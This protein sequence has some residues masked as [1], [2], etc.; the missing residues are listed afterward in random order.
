MNYIPYII[1]FALIFGTIGFVVYSNSEEAKSLRQGCDIE[2]IFTGVNVNNLS[3][4]QIKKMISDCD[5]QAVLNSAEQIALNNLGKIQSINDA[6]DIAEIFKGKPTVVQQTSFVNSNT[7]KEISEQEFIQLV[8]ATGDLTDEDIINIKITGGESFGHTPKYSNVELPDN[9]YLIGNPATF[10]GLLKK[11][12]EGSCKLNPETELVECKYVEPATFQYTF[13][14]SCEHRD[15]CALEPIT[16]PSEETNNDGTWTQ[17][18]QT[19]RFTEG[20]Y[21][22]SIQANSLVD[23][24]LTQRPYLIEVE[25][26]FQMVSP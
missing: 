8:N 23:N 7:G 15:F 5:A 12:I 16:R 6:G 25:K 22:M 9:H 2:Q 19:G 21:L 3:E 14:I 4:E 13:I 26:T 20:E 17:T 1:I 10:S 18:I 11:V 24:P